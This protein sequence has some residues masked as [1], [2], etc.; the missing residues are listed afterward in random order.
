MAKD[1]DYPAYDAGGRVEKY[2]E[3][4]EAKKMEGNRPPRPK[5]KKQGDQVVWNKEEK[6]WD[7]FTDEERQVPG[8]FRAMK[9]SPE[10]MRKKRKAKKILKGRAVVPISEMAKILV[11]ERKKSKK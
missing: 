7:Y 6:K 3:G 2:A 1:Y 11:E 8:S 9:Y 10:H 4:G 5:R